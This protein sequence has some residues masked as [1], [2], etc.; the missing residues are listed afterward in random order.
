VRLAQAQSPRLPFDAF[1]SGQCRVGSII[2]LRRCDDVH[3]VPGRGQVKRQIGEN[4]AGRGVIRKK[5]AIDE[6]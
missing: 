4:L 1:A 2:D 6:N 5:E 3:L